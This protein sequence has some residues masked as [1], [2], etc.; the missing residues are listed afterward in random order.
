MLA[1]GFRSWLSAYG[2]HLWDTFFYCKRRDINKI[3]LETSKQCESPCR[4]DVS[5]SRPQSVSVKIYWK[6]QR[7]QSR[8]HGHRAKTVKNTQVH[9]HGAPPLHCC[10]DNRLQWWE[11]LCFGLLEGLVETSG[12]E[13]RLCA[14]QRLVRKG[15]HEEIDSSLF[16]PTKVDSCSHDKTGWSTHVWMYELC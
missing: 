15:W 13:H 2:E 9:Q 4:W 3:K 1:W 14:E 8:G 12:A 7:R 16:L 6:Y 10:Q 11:C 5:W